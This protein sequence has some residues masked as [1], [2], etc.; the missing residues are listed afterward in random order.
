MTSS[1]I[2]V[3][4]DVFAEARFLA[5]SDSRDQV[6]GIRAD[7]VVEQRK[8]CCQW[9]SS[10]C[11]Q[12]AV[13]F[14]GLE[15]VAEGDHLLRS[16]WSVVASMLIYRAEPRSIAPQ[17]GWSCGWQFRPS[18]SLCAMP[19]EHFG[20]LVQPR[21]DARLLRPSNAGDDRLY[22]LAAQRSALRLDFV[23]PVKRVDE[24]LGAQGQEHADDDDADLAQ[25][26]API[27]HRM[28]MVMDS[29]GRPPP[30]RP[31]TGVSFRVSSDMPPPYGD[32]G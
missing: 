4:E 15:R 6:V 5:V 22:E 32:G 28:R 16:M 13:H 30:R 18:G 11:A 3:D 26:L 23:A 10:S 24:L 19:A 2:R 31:S 21:V 7:R 9:A 1:E 20:D 14:I 27:M 29:I 25:Q 17:N 8:P 12:I